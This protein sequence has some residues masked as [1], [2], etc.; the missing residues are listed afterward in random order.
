MCEKC[1]GANGTWSDE[2]LYCH[3]RRLAMWMLNRFVKTYGIPKQEIPDMEQEMIRGLLAAPQSYRNN[4]GGMYMIIRQ[5]ATIWVNK[6]HKWQ[7]VEETGKPLALRSEKHG[8]FEPHVGFTPSAVDSATRF[9]DPTNYREKFERER[10]AEQLVALMT[11]LPEPERIC[12]SFSYGIG[13]PRPL[14]LYMIARKLG[15]TIDW[16]KRRIARGEFLLRKSVSADSLNARG[17]HAR[18]SSGSTAARRSTASSA[19]QQLRAAV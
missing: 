9:P 14:S 7:R 5:T 17:Q 6:Y 15:V 1:A 18:R 3:Y 4:S 13:V 16:V 11:T 10:L 8:I 2:R 12:L 19:P